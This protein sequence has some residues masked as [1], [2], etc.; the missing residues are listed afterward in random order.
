[1]KEVYVTKSGL[2]ELKTR[3]EDLKSNKRLEVAAKIKFA[4][5][6]GDLSEN[7][8]YAAAKEEQGFLEQ[9][10]R[11]LEE[12]VLHAVIIE[13]SK[14][15]NAVA[16]GSTVKV[17]DVEFGDEEEYTIVG[18]TEADI[19]SG[20][21]SNESPLAVALLGKKKG[22]KAEVTTP[23]GSVVEYEIKEIK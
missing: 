12:K 18:T 20:K 15:K 8:E 9:E 6:L 19:A 21:I 16:I 4:R 14:D 13:E 22:D 2:E 17:L 3:L 1:M 11:E 23:N 10:I 5:E 7:A